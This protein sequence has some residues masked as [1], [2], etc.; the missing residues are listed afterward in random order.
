MERH[1]HHRQ[2]CHTRDATWAPIRPPSDSDPIRSERSAAAGPSNG[3]SNKSWCTTE[4]INTIKLKDRGERAEGRE[5]KKGQAQKEEVRHQGVNGGLGH[6]RVLLIRV[7]GE[8]A[9][10]QRPDPQVGSGK[11]SE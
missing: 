7:A 3:C 2:P 4:S 9:R 1:A 5:R 8:G 11:A 6:G 10:A